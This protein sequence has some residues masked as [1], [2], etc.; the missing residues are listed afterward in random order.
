MSS[1][2]LSVS[3]QPLPPE[4]DVHEFLLASDTRS[5]HPADAML[6]LR[7]HLDDLADTAAT[8]TF[9]QVVEDTDL[10]HHT[11]TT[12]MMWLVGSWQNPLSDKQRWVNP[13]HSNS[14]RYSDVVTRC[15]CGALMARVKEVY[16]ESP[17]DSDNEH[18]D[19]CTKQN[20]L[21][22][23]ARLCDARA[24][25]LRQGLAYGQTG[26]SMASRL[27][28]G[29][30]IGETAKDLGVDVEGLKAEYKQKR[31]NTLLHLLTDYTPAEAGKV[32]GI[33]GSRVREII[34]CDTPYNVGDFTDLRRAD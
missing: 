11:Y 26:R 2:A 7:D 9:S 6:A 10:T 8:F 4:G 1:E 5:L 32:Y 30:S 18:T 28:L 13:N 23:R 15:D 22:A 3:G 25:A 34:A 29:D 20:R 33:S 17:H 31:T 16:H 24:D 14:E 21:R 27:G 19:D 12:R